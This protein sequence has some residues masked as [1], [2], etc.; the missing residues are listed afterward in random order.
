MSTGKILIGAIAGLAAGAALGILFAPDKGSNT[1]KRLS[2]S[3]ED[4]MDDMKEK[5]D[6]FLETAKDQFG[7]AKEEAED[8]LEK[9]KAKT[10]DVKQDFKKDVKN[11][12]SY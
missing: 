1:R 4:F 7:N 5:F 11:T 9:G 2:Q 10:Q 8:F 12:M 6:D 3:G